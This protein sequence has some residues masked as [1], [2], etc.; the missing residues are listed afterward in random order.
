MRHFLSEQ[1]DFDNILLLAYHRTLKPRVLFR[2]S[3]SIEVHAKIETH[4]VNGLYRLDPFHSLYC[5]G[6]RSG[7]FRFRDLDLTRSKSALY[8]EEYYSQTTMIDEIAFFSSASNGW[9]LNLC[10]GTDGASGRSFGTGDLRRATTLSPLVDSLLAAHERRR[11]PLAPQ[12]P[13]VWTSG[14]IDRA[15]NSR[16]IS[17]TS[18]QLELTELLLQG[19]TAKSAA[20]L[21]GIS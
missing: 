11:W 13:S 20:R 18:R 5:R 7:V 8:V 12:V 19:H 10:I 2:Q 17:L 21:M 1:I 15:L 4:Y 14:P 3:R 16:G 6:T 9:T